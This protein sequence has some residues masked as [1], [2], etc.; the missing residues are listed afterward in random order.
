MNCNNCHSEISQTNRFCPQCGLDQYAHCYTLGEIYAKWKTRKYH[1]IS[2]KCKEGYELAWKRLLPL[3]DKPAMQIGLEELQEVLDKMLP[4]SHSNQH[5]VKCLISQLCKYSFLLG[6]GVR[7]NFAEYLELDGYNSK[8]TLIFEDSEI[9]SLFAYAKC[10]TNDYWKA[11]Q[12]T[13]LLIFTGLR[14]NELF[15]VRKGNVQI[16]E[17]CL[18][19]DGS[20]TDA[21]RKRLIP[22]VEAIW[23]F[24][25]ERYLS[26][27]A[28]TQDNAGLLF[29]GEKG[30]QYNLH[31]WRERE[32]YPLMLELTIN[33]PNFYGVR[34]RTPYS[35]RHTFASL[36]YRAGVEKEIL[37]KII[38]HT[39]W[40]FTAKTYVHAQMEQYKC[41]AAKIQTLLQE[42]S[43]PKEE[44]VWF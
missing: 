28:N 19:V 12:V 33:Q 8:E 21:G 7:M 22:I 2:A 36:A 15:A 39:T 4:T 9:F 41:E 13:L 38:G 11:A 30:A 5:K 17:R 32:F 31:N 40:E 37:K 35:C 25:A 16:R 1:R 20:K 10:R 44:T 34:R 24:L 42:I 29:R 3:A 43:H 6:N 23:P 26:A 27:K 18:V 14:P